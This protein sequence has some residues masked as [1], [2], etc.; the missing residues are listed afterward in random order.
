MG[1]GW[2]PGLTPSSQAA[3]FRSEEMLSCSSL[4]LTV[5]WGRE[6]QSRKTCRCLLKRGEVTTREQAPQEKVRLLSSGLRSSLSLPH[7]SHTGHEKAVLS[8]TA[9]TEP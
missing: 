5:H 9:T 8:S 6:G 2:A 1:L 7:R 4:T 3:N